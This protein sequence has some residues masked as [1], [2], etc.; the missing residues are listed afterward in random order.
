MD[1]PRP[2]DGKLALAVSA[3]AQQVK[4]LVPVNGQVA[5]AG[6]GN[7]AGMNKGD[8]YATAVIGLL[9]Q[10]RDGIRQLVAASAVKVIGVNANPTAALTAASAAKPTLAL[11]KKTGKGG[12]YKWSRALQPVT[13]A[14]KGTRM[15]RIGTKFLGRA[16]PAWKAMGG[17]RAAGGLGRLLGGAGGGGGL[18]GIFG[19]G[20]GA[21]GA[22][23]AGAGAAGAAGGGAAA[24]GAVAAP[25]AIVIAAGVAFKETTEA[26][27]DFARTCE[28][29][30]RALAEVSPSMAAI[31]AQRDA[32]RMGRDIDK[33]ENTSGTASKLADALD[34]WE[35]ATQPWGELLQNIENTIASELL[36]VVTS[37]FELVKPI[38]EALGVLVQRG[39][40]YGGD[41]DWMEK[42]YRQEQARAAASAARMDSLR[43]KHYRR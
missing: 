20:A 34:R 16:R 3:L 9:Q 26:I 21:G 5:G 41:T 33:G 27:V 15:G 23:G 12:G 19:G 38:A 17:G 14:L 39:E 2:E 30:N 32:N 35:T 29:A 25:I 1:D 28:Q 42:I 43:D 22:G 11:P 10:I 36:D 8:V 31:A 13:N 18:G 4:A 6:G 7:F 37:I 40:P 24:I